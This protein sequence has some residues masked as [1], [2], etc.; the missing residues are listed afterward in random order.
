MK[1]VLVLCHGNINRSAACAAILKSHGVEEVKSAGF[2]NPGRQAAKKMR[3]VL[4]E[5]PE[6]KSPYTRRYDLEDHR[7]QVVTQELIDWADLVVYMDGGNLKRLTSQ[8]AF[9]AGHH[10]ACLAEWDSPPEKRIPDP[11][12][13]ARGSEEFLETVGQI[14]RCS[15]NLAKYL[16]LE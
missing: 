16:V 5:Y 2:V 10:I 14:V 4:E 15:R 11:G 1:K 6:D 8:F 9:G 12:F 13:M 3:D 7:S